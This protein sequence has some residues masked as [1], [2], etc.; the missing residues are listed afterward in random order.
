MACDSKMPKVVQISLVGIQRLISHEAVSTDAANNLIN[1]LW[2]LMENE[3]EE[4][5]ILQTITLL[6]STNN[7]VQ[8][9]ALAKGLALCFRLHFTKNPTVNNA[10]SATIRQ[11]VSFVFERV[12]L[13]DSTSDVSAESGA[14]L[15]DLK[16]GSR[17]APRSLKPAAADAFLLFQDLV[18]IVNADQPYWLTGLTE[19]TRTFGLEL[20]E[21]IFNNFSTVF[22]R[23][24]EFSFLLKERVCPLVIKLFSPNIKYKPQHSAVGSTGSQNTTNV[25]ANNLSYSDKPFFP[26]ST[27]LLRIVNLLVQSFYTMLVSIY[28]LHVDLLYDI[29]YHLCSRSPN[30]KYFC[31][32]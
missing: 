31:H 3:L 26:I 1:C 27:R 32:Y 2:S 6:I 19:M 5:R 4:L 11:L 7:I 20:L 15:E 10:A 25:S 22:F 12:Q 8:G 9:D 16:T 18:Q 23:H 24:Q 28:N 13:E 29:N 14:N 30:A 21:N 17:Q